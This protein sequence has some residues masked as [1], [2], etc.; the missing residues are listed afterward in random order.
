MKIN[1]TKVYDLLGSVVVQ[2]ILFDQPSVISH[3]ISV[4]YSRV[5][6]LKRVFAFVFC[7]CFFL[8]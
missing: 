6:A 2:Y 8:L 3:I 1:R 5:G 4:L 7:Y